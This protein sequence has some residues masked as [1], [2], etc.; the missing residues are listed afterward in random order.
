ML[1]ARSAPA[2]HAA[3]PRA[4]ALARLVNVVI[5]PAAAFHDVRAAHPWA[6]ALTATIALRFLSLLI[7]YA[8]TVTPLKI[9]ASL[10]FQ[11]AAVVP[12]LLLGSTVAWLAAR[13]WRLRVGWPVIFSICT[14]VTA[15]YTLATIAFASVAGALLPESA[16]VD[17]RNPPFTNLGLLFEKTGTTA[18]LH[19]LGAEIDVRSLYAAVLLWLGL[20]A[21]G[22]PEPAARVGVLAGCAVTT[23]AV[24]RLVTV[25]MLAIASR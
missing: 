23:L 24:L 2:L 14:H 17:L 13:S 21:G 8:P 15:A 25:T 4:N 19:R 9:V 3:A 6:L 18:L 20:R 11:I 12:P 1:S 7:F 10:A 16:S 5:D 22:E